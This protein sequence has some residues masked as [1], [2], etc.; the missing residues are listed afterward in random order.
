MNL[1]DDRFDK[2]AKFTR[3]YDTLTLT[4]RFPGREDYSIS[5]DMQDPVLAD[6]T[7]GE[8]AEFLWFKAFTEFV[9]GLDDAALAWM[10]MGA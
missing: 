9:R 1:Y 7:E 6:Q 8:I 10:R 3:T 2:F 5:A 4:I